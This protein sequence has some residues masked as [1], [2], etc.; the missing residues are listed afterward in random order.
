MEEIIKKCWICKTNKADSREHKVL[1]AILDK[2]YN[3]SFHHK[4]DLGFFN[5]DYF[6]IL[7]SSGANL[8]K[9]SKT[10]CQY[11]NNSATQPSDNSF[12]I[13]WLLAVRDI[14]TIITTKQLSLSQF[15]EKNSLVFQMECKR[16]LA[17]LFGCSLAES[18]WSI[19][20]D[21]INFVSRKNDFSNL[22]F[23]VEINKD[24]MSVPNPWKYMLRIPVSKIIN[25][26]SYYMLYQLGPLR[27]NCFYNPSIDIE[28]L[29]DDNTQSISINIESFIDTSE[30]EILNDKSTDAKFLGNMLIRNH[31]FKV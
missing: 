15:S 24:V 28:N 10:I 20:E 7:K 26:K 5:N 23:T 6:Q 31:Y 1:K 22:I 4:N 18:K 21:I 30:R 25:D 19:P 12:Y 16:Y 11:C 27:F 14:E 8:L 29:W 13:L 3:K 17:K 9:F 2:V